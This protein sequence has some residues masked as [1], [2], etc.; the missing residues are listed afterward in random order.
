MQINDDLDTKKFQ[1]GVVGGGSWGT[2]LANLLASKGYAIKLWVFEKEVKDQILETGEN[3]VFLPD[4]KLSANLHPTNDMA[5]TVM[6]KDMVVVVVPS[7]L[8]RE[9]TSK[10]AEDVSKEAIIVTA[11]KGIEN[12]THLTMTGVLKETLAEIPHHRLVAISGPSFA[13]EVAREL[14]TVVTVASEDIKTA[15]LTQQVFATPYFR[16]Y[17]SEDVIG[18]ELGGSLKNVIAIG[19]GVVDGLGL[20]LNARA[21]LITRGMTEIRRLGLKLGANPRTFTGLAGIGDLILT[22]TGDLSRNHTVGVKIGQGKKISDILS[23]MR[24]V[25]EGVKTARSVY[26]LSRKLGVDMPI[27]HEAYRILYED[28]SPKEAIYRLMTRDLK[29]ELDEE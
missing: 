28:F 5:E 8:M 4:V 11:S 17:T 19:A 29:Q 16:V 12:K 22:C 25:A 1:I 6:G 2:A 27:F 24:M 14:P 18:V 21:A 15:A 26:N 23:E 7:H 9:I 3:K 13:R 10:T 20:G